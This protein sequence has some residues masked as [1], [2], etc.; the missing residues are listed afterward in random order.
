MATIYKRKGSANWHYRF[1]IGR[2]E[3]RGSCG[4]ANEREARRI[5]NDKVEEAKVQAEK[6]KG[7]RLSFG[8]AVVRFFEE[9]ATD[10]RPKTLDNYKHDVRVWLPWIGELY[11]D[12]IDADLIRAFMVTRRKVVS[13]RTVQAN[14]A[15]LSTLFTYMSD[16][17]DGPKHNPVRDVSKKRLRTNKRR[18]FATVSEF[19]TLL[20]S[21]SSETY[22]NIIILAVETGMRSGELRTLTWDQVQLKRREIHLVETKNHEPRVIPLS[23]AAVLALVGTVRHRSAQ[24]VFWYGDGQP[25]TTFKNWWRG[26]CRRAGMS[27]F[28]FH[29]LRHTFASWWIQSGRSDKAAREIMGHLTASLTDR[30]THLRTEDLHIA[31]SAQSS[32]QEALIKSAQPKGES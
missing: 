19:K 30:Y 6:A 15:F 2:K 18:R 27:D 13:D 8:E 28:K 16:Y 31:M 9:A 14:L 23:D 10:L 26:T 4:T 29:D 11:L 25:Y 22:R 20:D 1:Q 24:W 21:C 5:L 12:E 7:P 32:A 3:V 17:P